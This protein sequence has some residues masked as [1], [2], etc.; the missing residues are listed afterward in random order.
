MLELSVRQK[1]ARILGSRRSMKIS[2]IFKPTIALKGTIFGR[3]VWILGKW[4]LNAAKSS[5]SASFASAGICT[6]T[7]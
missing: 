4:G 2:Y 1:L 3:A 5:A 6:G 7:G